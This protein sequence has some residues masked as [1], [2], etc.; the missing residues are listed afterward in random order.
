[1]C[2]E[3]GAASGVY[4]FPCIVHTEAEE[5]AEHIVEEKWVISGGEG[6]GAA[7]DEETYNAWPVCEL[8]FEG[9]RATMGK[10]TK[11]KT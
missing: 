5:S 1:M 4:P 7:G 9:D 8:E 10:H 2:S 11:Q 3:T 6:T